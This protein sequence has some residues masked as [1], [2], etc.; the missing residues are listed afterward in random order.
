MRQLR[1][2]ALVLIDPVRLSLRTDRTVE[3]SKDEEREGS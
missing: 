1:L 3:A 2:A